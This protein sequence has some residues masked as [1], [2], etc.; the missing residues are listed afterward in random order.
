MSY[1]SG[2][3]YWLYFSGTIIDLKWKATELCEVYAPT[4]NNGQT[5]AHQS[6]KS[7]NHSSLEGTVRRWQRRKK[8]LASI[9]LKKKKYNSKKQWG[10]TLTGVY[11]QPE[12][13]NAMCYHLRKGW[14]T[15]RGMEFT[16][17]RW[18]GAAAG[19]GYSSGPRPENWPLAKGRK[20]KGVEVYCSW[21]GTGKSFWWPGDQKTVT[22]WYL[23]LKISSIKFRLW[24]NL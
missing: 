24:P 23:L 9:Y 14:E 12:K 17:G 18:H 16:R 8:I 6:W 22:S 5:T 7:L 21:E 1:L 19:K 15:A 10:M 11:I 2:I 20:P 3:Y 13:S 4:G